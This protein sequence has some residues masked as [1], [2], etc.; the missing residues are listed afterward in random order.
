MLLKPKHVK[1]FQEEVTAL[2]IINRN[3]IIYGLKTKILVYKGL[4][5]G[6]LHH[7]IDVARMFHEQQDS[8]TPIYSYSLCSLQDEILKIA[9]LSPATE[10]EYKL[11]HKQAF[12]RVTVHDL[13]DDDKSFK[14]GPLNWDVGSISL[15]AEGKLLVVVSSDGVYVSIY[16]TYRFAEAT[17]SLIS[18]ILTY[19]RGSSPCKLSRPVQII[20]VQHID[21]G[22]SRP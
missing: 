17:S 5:S 15:D 3:Y 10:V 13:M 22:V 12:R 21:E 8:L 7:T 20:N 1:M 6:F 14:V 16:S 4:T 11:Q 19:C 9:A 18:P 2:E